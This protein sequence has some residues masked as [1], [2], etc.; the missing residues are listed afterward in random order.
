MTRLISRSSIQS[1]GG[2]VVS[3]GK[4]RSLFENR[5]GLLSAE[6]KRRF[7][8]I[9]LLDWLAHVSANGIV[10]ALTNGALF[11][12]RDRA[13]FDDLRLDVRHGAN[14]KQTAAFAGIG[15]DEDVSPILDGGRGILRRWRRRLH[16]RVRQVHVIVLLR[17]VLVAMV[18]EVANL[19]GMS[20]QRRRD[21]PDDERKPL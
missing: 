4:E 19:S 12:C 1:R 10:G 15:L 16:V 2:V 21:K 17:L 14:P 9:A 13:D 18:F 8:V 7:N 6:P 20:D 5:L 3:V 11:V